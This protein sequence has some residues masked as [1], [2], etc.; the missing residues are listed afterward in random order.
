M[1][2]FIIRVF[3]AMLLLFICFGSIYRVI[4]VILSKYYFDLEDTFLI[5][6]PFFFF[7]VKGFMVADLNF[8][9]NSGSS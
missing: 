2:L 4:L 6:L 8:P 5:A 1:T 3:I 7:F 9:V